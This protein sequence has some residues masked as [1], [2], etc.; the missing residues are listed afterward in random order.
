MSREDIF[1]FQNLQQAILCHRDSRI[2][3]NPPPS[4]FY[5]LGIPKALTLKLRY[6]ILAGYNENLLPDLPR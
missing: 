3:P 6:R 5:D 2:F 1:D 4:T